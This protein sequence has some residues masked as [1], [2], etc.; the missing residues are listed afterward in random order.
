MRSSMRPD[1]SAAAA[2]AADGDDDDAY[3]VVELS[4]H[5]DCSRCDGDAT[6]GVE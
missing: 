5:F 1:E 4:M 3:V 6:I 2:V